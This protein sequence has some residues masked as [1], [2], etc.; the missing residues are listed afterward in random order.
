MDCTIRLHKDHNYDLVADVLTQHK[1]ELVSSLKPVK[2]KLVTVQQALKDFDTRVKAIHN[3]RATIEA[4]IHREIDQQHALLDQRRTELVGEL[5]MLTQQK[6]K[7]LV[8]QRDHVELT[9][10]KLSS[11]LEHA[12]GGLKTDSHTDGEVLETKASVLKRVEQISA[13]FDPST[14]SPETMA[15]MEMVTSGKE[16]LQQAC[17][18]FLDIDYM[19]PVDCSVQRTAT[20]RE[21][22]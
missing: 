16:S 22:V 2:E 3:Q 8:T 5:E 6:I 13:D 17:R 11:C 9:E 19:L 1:E 18:G 12:E 21:M 15:D 7:A 4:D 14:L 10:A 20:R